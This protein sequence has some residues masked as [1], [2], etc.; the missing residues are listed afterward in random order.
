MKNSKITYDRH[1][2]VPPHDGNELDQT[3]GAML[4][5]TV[6]DSAPLAIMVVNQN[7]QIVETNRRFRSL[8]PRCGDEKACL[9]YR[10]IPPEPRNTP[11]P[12]CLV[13]KTFISGE[14]LSIEDSIRRDDGE[15]H[16]R[17]RTS[18]VFSPKGEV[19]AVMQT[20]EDITE[21][22]ANESRLE[23]NNREL[24]KAINERLRAQ[25]DKEKN[26]TALI[27]TVYEIKGAHN[28]QESMDK[29]TGGFRELGARAVA[30]AL[31]NGEH[32]NLAWI[33]PLDLVNRLNSLFRV[34]SIMDV[35]LKQERH[36]ENPLIHTSLV[37]KPVFYRGDT[38]IYN[39]FKECFYNNYDHEIAEAAY[40]FQGQSMVIFPLKTKDISV[41]T[42]ALSAD[43]DIL[44]Q[45]IE[46]YN[47]LSSSAAVEISRQQ[48]SQK[49]ARSEM[50]YRN[51]VERSRDMIILCACDGKIR[52]SNPSFYDLTGISKNSRKDLNIFSFFNNGNRTKIREIVT[53]G[54]DSNMPTEP[55]EMEMKVPGKKPLWT[56]MIINP[57]VEEFKGFQIVARDIT[58]R[59]NLELLVGNL[60]AFQ[61]K[62]LQNDA[63]GII[64][65]D[66][67]GVIS[68]W[69]RGAS[70]I[71]GYGSGEMIDR[72]IK[73]FIVAESLAG[74]AELK[75]GDPS[76]H[77]S[78]EL[79]FRKKDGLA[80]YVLYVESTMKEESGKPIA[81]IAFFFDNTEKVKL[82]E[83]WR[84]L[85]FRL[86]QAQLITIVSLAKLAEYRDIETG[87]HLE[88][89]MKYTETLAKELAVF[90]EYRDYITDEY[91]IDLVNSCPLHDIGKVGIPDSILHKPARLTPEEFEIIK[92]HSV[93][94]GDTIAEAEKKVK[95]R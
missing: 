92:K 39:F 75:K 4:Y 46:Y 10:V 95:G 72:D 91:I 14:E 56:E 50:K 43:T 76:F 29:I 44:E 37:G 22:I 60:P 67:S 36:A 70:N 63:I 17:R 59:K 88:R 3:I 54:L 65:T 45:N 68:S 90:P 47:F 55:L 26:L 21:L 40:M 57:V 53:A 58:Q 13:R 81:I 20:F 74:A 15:F 28:I 48:S 89:I 2:D 41:G 18:P 6:F 34:K 31:F 79:Q 9:C 87:M 78:R 62:I 61:E 86:Q 35:R 12:E 93:I 25:R 64:T 49:L 52:Y 16:C 77:R 24:E 19:A 11:C 27:N 73:D 7:F 51:L 84:E 5:R 82:E 71:L 32:M 80:V 85:S 8:Y 1:K 83:K 94:G 23:Q 69:N 38:E 42:I 66:L 30:F 33:Y